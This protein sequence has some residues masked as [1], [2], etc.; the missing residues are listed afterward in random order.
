MVSSTIGSI[1]RYSVV[2]RPRTYLLTFGTAVLVW[3][4]GITT[5]GGAYDGGA[6][7]AV[8]GAFAFALS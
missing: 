6:T 2:E 5:A 7:K 1:N 4:F 3:T 8:T